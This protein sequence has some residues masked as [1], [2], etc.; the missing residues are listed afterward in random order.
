MAMQ[1]ET[2][3]VNEDLE[4]VGNF[5][6]LVLSHAGIRSVPKSLHITVT[7]VFIVYVN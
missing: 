5:L 4:Y 3:E 2:N 1:F 7:V 6:D